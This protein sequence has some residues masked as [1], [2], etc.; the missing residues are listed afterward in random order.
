MI[1]LKFCIHIYIFAAYHAGNCIFIKHA[2]SKDTLK[3]TPLV[4]LAFFLHISI[5]IWHYECLA[6]SRI[7]L[8]H[9]LKSAHIS[10]TITF[11]STG[12]A[13][14]LRSTTQLHPQYCGYGCLRNRIRLQ[15]RCDFNRTGENRDLKK[16]R[17]F[18]NAYY[19]S[20]SHHIKILKYFS[21]F[22]DASSNTFN[23]QF[24]SF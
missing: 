11:I 10:Y 24:I 12:F 4:F 14:K 1:S 3:S 8:L 2:F 19:M 9:S 7:L 20:F 17:G 21:D 13:F 23:T 16:E 6:C 15:L 22:R 5:S 18:L